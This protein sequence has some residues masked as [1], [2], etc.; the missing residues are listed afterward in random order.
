MSIDL[1]NATPVRAIAR[2]KTKGCRNVYRVDFHTTY[3]T[4]PH[5]GRMAARR[6]VI[7]DG[8]ETSYRELADMKRIV[9]RGKTCGCG[10]LL[11]MKIV[12]GSY[13][14]AHNCGPRCRNAVGPSCECSCAGENHGA[15][16]GTV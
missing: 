3:E 10:A 5:A 12:E 6:T 15:G 13:S 16:H 9:M 14:E 4:F 8:R 2:C 1:A 7:V 11:G